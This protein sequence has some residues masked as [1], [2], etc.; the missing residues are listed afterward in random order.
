VAIIYAG[1]KN[2]L[3]EVPVDKIKEFESEYIQVLNNKHGKILKEIKQGKLTDE[4]INTLEKLCNELSA[5]Y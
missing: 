3:R 4:V 2:L 1:S 5:K